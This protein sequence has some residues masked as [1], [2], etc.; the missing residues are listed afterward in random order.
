[1]SLQDVKD[2]PGSDASREHPSSFIP[3]SARAA[4]DKN[5]TIE[6]YMYYAKQTR[7]E[8]RVALPNPE[9]STGMIDQV[10]RRTSVEQTLA[11]APPADGHESPS[12]SNEKEKHGATSDLGRAVITKDEWRDASR[13]MRT[14]SC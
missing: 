8:E 7:E 2:T 5:V 13:L 14:A 4:Y 9:K 10:F 1:M 12:D 3:P 11:A 6:E